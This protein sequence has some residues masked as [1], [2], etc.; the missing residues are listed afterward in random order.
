MPSL[1]HE[2]ASTLFH[3]KG[4]RRTG[5]LF[6]LLGMLKP[7]TRLE[8]SLFT[9]ALQD[10]VE[11]TRDD[12]GVPHIQ[13]AHMLDALFVQGFVHGRERAFQM[14]LSRRLPQGQLSELLGPAGLP[15]DRFMRRL[16][17]SYWAN[18]APA[19]WSENTQA[20][21]ARYVDGVNYAFQTQPLPPE[22]RFLKAPLR[23]W[24]VQDSNAIIYQLAWTLNSIWNSKWVFDQLDSQDETKS[25]LFGPLDVDTPTIVP[26][27]GCYDAWGT[28]GV[29]S[30][31]WVVDGAH[32]E[33]GGPLLANDPHLMPQLPSI[34]YEMFL[35]GGPM[36]VFGASLPGSPGII[37]GQ[38]QHIAWGVTNVDPDVQDL[39]RIQMEPDGEHY[40]IDGELKALQTRTEVIHVRGKSD[41]TLTCAQSE[42]G[43]IIFDEAGGKKIALSWTGFQPLPMVQ[44][45]LRI[46][47]AHDWETFNN[48]LAEWWVPA[49]N[50]VYAD[51]AGHIGYIAAGRIPTRDGGPWR[52]VV[53]GNDGRYK[54]TGW[55]EWTEMPRIVDPEQGYIVTANNPVVGNADTAPLFGRYSLG[56][57]AQRIGELIRQR[58]KHS[59]ESFKAIQRDVFSQ[60]LLQLARLLDQESIPAPWR[61]ALKGFSGEAS[62]DSPA[63]T[64]LYFFAVHA[65]PQAVRKGLDRPF[66]PGVKPGNPGTHPFPENFWELM[67][68]RLLSAVIM[69]WAEIDVAAAV[70]SAHS[71]LQEAFGP[72]PA[73]WAWGK[74]HQAQLFHPFTAVKM[75]QPLFGRKPLPMG[76]DLYTPLQTAFALDPQLPWPRGVSF[77]PSYR[78]IMDVVAP[79]ESIAVHLTGQSGHPLSSHYDNLIAPYLDGTYFPLGPGMMTHAWFQMAPKKS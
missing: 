55:R 61:Q 19:T 66:F 40:Q 25:W 72:T 6:R 21:V 4:F 69:H 49:Q 24:T 30:N 60:P 41:E 50:F 64:V 7:V 35:E 1:R 13:A 26:N 23:E 52:G 8:P 39:H 62:A 36:H 15:Y 18:Q 29:G 54:W 38:N 78:Q 44:A 53:D 28:I 48:A 67:G 34:W 11:I 43:P 51:S 77:M 2:N 10:V 27:T 31:N 17:V 22:H 20:Y 37:I 71:R 46:N 79:V 33:T 73:N 75:L 3:L 12:V 5:H 14:D 65:V 68:E 56:V 32:S 74:A 9:S 42:W 57:R 70:R 45:V 63:P 59:A 76:G 58:P 47:R 16:N